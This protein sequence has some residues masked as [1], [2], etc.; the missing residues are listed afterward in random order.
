MIILVGCTGKLKYLIKAAWLPIDRD[1][2]V[3]N[4]PGADMA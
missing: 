3:F 2:S 4:Q 1:L